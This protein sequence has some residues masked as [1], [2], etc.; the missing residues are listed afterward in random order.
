M[1][2]PALAKLVQTSFR[3][4]LPFLNG[5]VKPIAKTQ[6]CTGLH[7]V[8]TSKQ[9]KLA[10]WSNLLCIAILAVRILSRK[11]IKATLLVTYTE[12]IEQEQDF[13]RQAPLRLSQRAHKLRYTRTHMVKVIQSNK[14]FSFHGRVFEHVQWLASAACVTLHRFTRRCRLT[15]EDR[16]CNVKFC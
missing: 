5:N 1:C 14:Q 8:S 9:V 7:L 4:I 12:H 6:C 15:Y 10:C 16:V 11:S 3:L 2:T 13:M